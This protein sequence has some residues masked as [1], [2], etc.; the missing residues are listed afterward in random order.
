[1]ATQGFK[2]TQ[3]FPI[4]ALAG[5]FAAGF[6]RSPDAPGALFTRECIALHVVNEIA[7]DDVEA[8]TNLADTSQSVQ[9]LFGH[10]AEATPQR[11]GIRLR[12]LLVAFSS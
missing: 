5:G 12:I 1:M 7:Q 10:P 9:S 6:L 11:T 4:T 3:I 2:P 8:C